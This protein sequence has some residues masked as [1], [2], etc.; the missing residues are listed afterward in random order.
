MVLGYNELTDPERAVWEAVETGKLVDL[1]PGDTGRDDPANGATWSADR[2]VRAQLLYE[3][4]TGIS[5]PKEF[6]P[7]AL[8]L[9]GAWITGALDLEAVALECPLLLRGC[10]LDRPITLDEARAPALRLPGCHVVSL[11]AD[12]LETRGSVELNEGFTAH[13]EVRLGGAHIGGQLNFA[14]ATLTNP[15]GAALAADGLTVSADMAC[16]EGFTASG[17]VRLLGAHIGGNLYFYGATLTNPGEVAFG[18]DGLVVDQFMFCRNGFTASGEIR[19]LGAHIGGQLNFDGATL[20]NPGEVALNADGLVVDQDMFC[21]NGFTASG[22][23]RL[24]GAHIGGQLNF[25]GAT[26]TN[27]G[28]VALNADA[29]VVDQYM[30]C[31]NGF[32]ASGEVLLLGAQVSGQLNFDGATLTNPGGVALRADWLTVDQAMLCY[33]GFRAQGEVILGGAHIGSNLQLQGATLT[34]PGGVALN[35]NGLVVDQNMFCNG[36]TA[37]GEVILIGAQVGG[38]LNFDG[39]TLSNPDGVALDLQEL[40][41]KA[42]LLRLETPPDGGIDFTHAQVGV[43]LDEQ[44]TWPAILD[45]RGFVYDALYERTHISVAARLRWLDRG[46]AGYAPQPYEQLVAV[47]RRAGRDDH[48]RKVAIAKQRRRRETLNRP[49]RVWNSLLRWTVGYGYRTWQAGLW[50]LGLLAVGAAVFAWAYPGEMALAKKPGDPLPAFQPWMYSLDVLLPVVN[51]HQEEFW[52]PQGVARWWVWFSI[53]AGWL[54]TTVV[55]AAVTGL[56]K[57]D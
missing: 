16:C 41:A 44:A 10:Y 23:I 50:L 3:L 22:E 51:L 33:G 53:L 47:Y 8:R 48:A 31:R 30:L 43:F 5:K 57:K 18:A 4:L 26:L 36:F 39:A 19:L 34:N 7:R 11:H 55:I 37:R 35:A 46:R 32:T 25:D 40:R 13:G 20:T 17:E 49:S 12:Q 24:L 56:L 1:R 27:P 9:A 52:I 14:G 38:Q 45:L 54:L 15:D 21:R 6:S 29:L 42:L 2:Q 28:E